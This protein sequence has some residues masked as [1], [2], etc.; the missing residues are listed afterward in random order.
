[1]TT[2]GEKIIVQANVLDLQHIGPNTRHNGCQ[3]GVRDCHVGR[4]GG[5]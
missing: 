4:L 2:Q 1:V 5:V 3:G